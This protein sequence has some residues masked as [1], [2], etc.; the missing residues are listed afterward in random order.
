MPPGCR[1]AE[2]SGHPHGSL[3]VEA[4]ALSLRRCD[5]RVPESHRGRH[6]SQWW[7]RLDV[8]SSLASPH[9]LEAVASAVTPVGGCHPCQWFV[10]CAAVCGEDVLPLFSRGDL[11]LWG[12]LGTHSL[13]T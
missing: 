10:P 9:I 13:Q 6:R 2:R 11:G 3:W 8:V 4:A 1:A 12:A 7:V 5:S